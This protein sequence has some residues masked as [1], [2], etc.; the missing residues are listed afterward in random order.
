MKKLF[1]RWIISQFIRLLPPVEYVL[2]PKEQEKLYK[3]LAESWGTKNLR[4]YFLTRDY[5][6]L[7]ELGN[8]CDREKYLILI[9]RRLELLQLVSEGQNWWNKLEGEKQKKAK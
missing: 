5:A 9:G 7:K 6:I 2:K 1:H 3:W 8:K 4:S